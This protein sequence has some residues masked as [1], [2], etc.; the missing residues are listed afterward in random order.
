M[1]SLHP[2]RLPQVHSPCQLLATFAAGAFLLASAPLVL[3]S[4]AH[5][6]SC[7]ELAH[8]ALPDAT[9]TKVETV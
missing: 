1:P 7:E 3:S 5:A 6:Q 2:R 4:Q 8:L 9:F